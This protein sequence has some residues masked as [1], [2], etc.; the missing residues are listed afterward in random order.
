MPES[1]PIDPNFHLDINLEDF[2]VESTSDIAFALF[3]KRV[4]RDY[5]SLKD[6]L[7]KNPAWEGNENDI[8][9]Y[10][11]AGLSSLTIQDGTPGFPMY[12]SSRIMFLKDLENT[13]KYDLKKLKYI[14]DY[15]EILIDD[16]Y[17]PDALVYSG[18]PTV[19]LYR[20]Y[21]KERIADDKEILNHCET[22]DDKNEHLIRIKNNEA[23]INYLEGKKLEELSE[24]LQE[25]INRE[26]FRIKFLSVQLNPGFD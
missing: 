5:T 1:F 20:A 17:V 16:V 25:A 9:R 19:D 6:E 21:L 18:L 10:I 7:S 12:A 13:W 11:E 4:L 3:N 8:K 22:L 14:S 2:S 24:E 26:V 15:E 23:G